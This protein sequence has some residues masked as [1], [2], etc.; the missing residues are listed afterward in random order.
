MASAGLLGGEALGVSLD[1]DGVGQALIYPYFTVQNDAGGNS[2]NTY[3]SVVNRRADAKVLRVR[4]REGR[5]GREI[6][7]FN[8]YLAP[9]DMW[10][11]AVIPT[12]AHPLASGRI[13][14]A[15]SSCVNPRLPAPG[16]PFSSAAFTGAGADGLGDGL[17]RTREG[18]IEIIEMATLR[19]AALAALTN[20]DGFLPDCTTLQGDAVTLTGQLA[21]PTGGL[22]GTLTLLNVNSGMDLG[23][24]ALALAELTAAPF[25]RNFTDR[26]PGFDAAE[27]V[28][29]S[30]VTAN[31]RAYD[32]R[33]RNGVEAVTSVFMA[34]EVLNEYVLD[35]G[36]RSQTDWVLT[37]PTRPFLPGNAA[38]FV[39]ETFHVVR[40]YYD[41]ESRTRS[42]A[43]GETCSF[44]SA[45]CPPLSLRPVAGAFAV[46]NDGTTK[47]VLGSV[48]GLRLGEIGGFTSG[49]MRV[50]VAEGPGELGRLRSEP[51]SISTDL[52]TG[53]VTSGRFEVRGLPWVGFMVRTFNNGTLS[54]AAGACQG[55]YAGAFAHRVVRS[56]DLVP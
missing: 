27:V 52:A 7:S 51:G 19:G 13:I 37:F 45:P 46:A 8:L 33:W 55:N 12:S 49:W 20:L 11:A 2:W 22:S 9:N 44:A 53:A 16:A 40:D 14:S 18:Y 21:P 32:L 42:E 3:I 29:V 31:G 38:P 15:D 1:A 35:P 5:N 48:N 34:T 47:S 23:V 6:G 30:H 39:H 50:R 24:N 26:Y 41:R 10:S 54:C 56:I 17:D 4:V 25:Y 36:T 43:P 28:P